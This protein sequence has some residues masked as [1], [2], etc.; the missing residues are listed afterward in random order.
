MNGVLIGVEGENPCSQ[1]LA[2][3]VGVYFLNVVK[4]TAITCYKRLTDSLACRND[5]GFT[6]F[7]I[8]K[9]IIN[10]CLTISFIMPPLV[11]FGLLSTVALL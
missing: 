2:V 10:N 1:Q 11:G 6:T 7:T 3:K 4:E 5:R 8:D 9:L